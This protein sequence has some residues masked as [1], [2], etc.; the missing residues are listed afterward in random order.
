MYI[1]DSI[2]LEWQSVD[3]EV[4]DSSLTST[5]GA[6]MHI[7]HACIQSIHSCKMGMLLIYY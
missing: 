3:G 6:Q 5:A 1:V 7:R 4:S 2:L